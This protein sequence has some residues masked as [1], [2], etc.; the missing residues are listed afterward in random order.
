[1]QDIL[2][3]WVF[4]KCVQK[5]ASLKK[6]SLGKTPYNQVVIDLAVY[7]LKI[8]VVLRLRDAVHHASVVCPLCC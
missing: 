3:L 4:T 8:S 6:G 2:V 7:T 5:F 1:M